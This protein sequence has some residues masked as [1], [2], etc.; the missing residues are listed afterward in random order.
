MRSF[1]VHSFKELFSLSVFV[2]ENP[3]NVEE[4]FCISM[5]QS[6]PIQSSFCVDPQVQLT[7]V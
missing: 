3:A 7:C 5:A 2:T 6:F 1:L 4:Y